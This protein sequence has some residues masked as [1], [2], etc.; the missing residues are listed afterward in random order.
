MQSIAQSRHLNHMLV[1]KVWAQASNSAECGIRD[2]GWGVRTDCGFAPWGHPLS[3]SRSSGHQRDQ[4]NLRAGA[5]AQRDAFTYP[6]RDVKLRLAALE[7]TGGFVAR[8]MLGLSMDC[9]DQGQYDLSAVR[10]P[11]EHHICLLHGRIVQ[12]V[13]IMAE[14]NRRLMG[15]YARQCLLYIGPTFLQI[16]HTRQIEVHAFALD[17]LL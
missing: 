16:I 8:Q 14:Q 15:R 2:T 11:G 3:H 17:P 12:H 9:A 5:K 1:Y 10:M 6:A 7:M 4:R 13:G